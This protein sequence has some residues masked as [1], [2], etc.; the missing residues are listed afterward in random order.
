M[1][2][3][4]YFYFYFLAIHILIH[5]FN[6]IL[7]DWTKKFHKKKL[8]IKTGSEFTTKSISSEL[9]FMGGKI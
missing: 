4:E 5:M 3:E 2:E 1:E 9:K 6:T 8:S 7:D